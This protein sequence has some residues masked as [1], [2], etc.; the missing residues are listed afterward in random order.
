M[1]LMKNIEYDAVSKT[2]SVGAGLTWKE[3]YKWFSDH[4]LAI[5]VNGATSCD[6]VG[7][8]GF[9]LGGGYGNKCNQFGLAMDC[10]EKIE[11][12]L[13]TGEVVVT[14]VEEAKPGSLFWALRVRCAYPNLFLRVLRIHDY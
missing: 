9:L 4:Q 8:A 10:I 13:P 12:V 11:V 1:G 5:N 7:V 3:L 6:G 2:V 14:T